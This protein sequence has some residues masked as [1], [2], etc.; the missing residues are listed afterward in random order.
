VYETHPDERYR[1]FLADKATRMARR[2]Y[3][4]Y[5]HAFV[6]LYGNDTAV[7][8]KAVEEAKRLDR[9]S[10]HLAAALAKSEK[11]ARK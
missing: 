3:Q 8:A 2:T 9:A 6:A 11:Q 4:A 7:R 10:M 1:R 5:A